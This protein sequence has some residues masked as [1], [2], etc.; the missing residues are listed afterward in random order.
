MPTSADG[1]T[2][3]TSPSS[4]VVELVTP[5]ATLCASYRAL[6]AEFVDHREK[7]VPFVLGFEHGDCDAML[8]R[9]AACSRGLGLPDGFVAHSTYWLVE[10]R[11]NVVGVCNIRHALT[12]ALLREGGHIGYGVRPSARGRGLGTEILRQS[13]RRA[14]DLGIGDILVT[15][16][17]SNVAS[18]RAII[19]NGG[20][21]DSQTFLPDRGEIVQRYWIRAASDDRP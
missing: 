10:D 17:Q 19:R 14:R 16:G 13:L 2:G 7:L 8:A 4:C 5:D 21:L 3:R 9:L 12:P 1:V 20:V 15:C 11:T 6:V 18:A